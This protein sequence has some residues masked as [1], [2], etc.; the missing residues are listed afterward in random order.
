MLTCDFCHRA[1]S[2][3]YI[4][5]E[6]GV[7]ICATCHR[8]L[9][10]C[11]ACGLAVKQIVTQQG[12]TYCN[13]C[14]KKVPRCAFC[15]VYIFGKYYQIDNQNVCIS[16]HQKLPQCVHCGRPMQD[17]LAVG[18]DKLCLA[19]S[20]TIDHCSICQIPL[21]HDYF[22]FE[23][24]AR[25][26]CPHCANSRGRCDVC[27]LPLTNIYHR[28][29]DQRTIC[30]KCMKEAVANPAT[31]QKAL[32]QVLSYF[33]STWDMRIRDTTQLRLVDDQVLRKLR[34]NLKAPGNK[35]RRAL[36][37]FLR[38]GE[39]FEVFLATFLPYP[40]CVW[41]LAHEYT[42]A[43]QAEHFSS[44][45]SLL[46]IEG[47]AEWCAYHTLRHYGYQKEAALVTKQQD[48]YGQ[49][50]KKIME[51]ERKHRS[52]NVIGQVLQMAGKGR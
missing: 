4:Q 6:N 13:S 45:A 21:I 18:S 48:V 15:R 2:G 26:F 14:I 25:K 8:T 19:C 11:A 46:L 24:D 29:H 12:K 16:C 32:D 35:D 1:I 3:R 27:S 20:Q 37:L 30:A 51:I 17:Y 34:H 43:W 49:G 5:Y 23:G 44:H 40:L 28:L 31:A 38:K 42:H 41:V 36:G 10:H 47:L 50:F 33:R 22:S 9:P 52:T 7:K 39:S